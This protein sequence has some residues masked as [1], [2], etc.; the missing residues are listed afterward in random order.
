[1]EVTTNEATGN[2]NVEASQLTNV[3]KIL[4]S[5]YG[6]FAFGTIL[7]LAVHF[8]AVKPTLESKAKDA[9]TIN[10]LV[11]SIEAQSI[12]MRELSSNLDTTT[13]GLKVSA[14]ILEKTVERLERLQ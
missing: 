13:E 6:P 8:Y 10:Q 4:G 2:H 9:E 7:F 3:L 11:Q 12:A 1:M 5:Q 14:I